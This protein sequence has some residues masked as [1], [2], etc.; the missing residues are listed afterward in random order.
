MPRFMYLIKADKMAEGDMKDVPI[1]IFEEMN[2]YNES[3]NEAGLL[4]DAGG[5]APTKLD[6]Y[7]LKYSGSGEPEVQSGPFD[8]EAEAHVCGYW[9]VKTKDAEEALTWAKKIPFKG[10]E[11]T[12]RRIADTADIE[13]FPEDLK[14]KEDKIFADAAARAKQ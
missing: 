2:K 3:L 11:L 9:V 1:G 10:G 8:V 4:I 7:R 13:N 12:V 14:K 6:A 5:F